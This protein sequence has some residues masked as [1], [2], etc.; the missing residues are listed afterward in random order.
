MH[1]KRQH[2]QGPMQSQVLKMSTTLQTNL[3]TAMVNASYT[4]VKMAINTVPVVCRDSVKLD[5]GQTRH[6][7]AQV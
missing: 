4:H 1:F 7:Y 2:A 5:P 6:Q 3:N